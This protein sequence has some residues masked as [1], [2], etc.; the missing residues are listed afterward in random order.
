MG[1]LFNQWRQS[2]L[3][4]IMSLIAAILKRICRGMNNVFGMFGRIFLWLVLILFLIFFLPF[5]VLATPEVKAYRNL[6]PTMDMCREGLDSGWS[7]LADADSSNDENAAI[8]KDKSKPWGTLLRCALQRHVIPSQSGKKQLDYHLS[9]LEFNESGEPYRLV[10]RG[11]NGD[12]TISS[13]KF[14]ELLPKDYR[15][16][17]AKKQRDAVPITQLDVLRHHLM[18]TPSNYV[19]VF[20]HGW[21]HDAS[22]GDTNVS[23]LRLYA[24]HAARF[25]EQRCEM[26][27]LYCD[28]KVTAVYIGWRGAR[29]NEAFLRRIFRRVY[30]R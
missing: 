3:F 17:D 5:F 24:A 21:R 6:H 11:E 1:Q 19:I 29:V 30:R 9:F 10:W 4:G 15:E 2:K 13:K 27:G 16:L 14:N 7:I 22:I 23:D 12:E 25:L 28:T 18:K 8:A 20:A 26:E